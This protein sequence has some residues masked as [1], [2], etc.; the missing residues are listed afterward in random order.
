MHVLFF[1]INNEKFI[2][3]LSFISIVKTLDVF[4]YLQKKKSI[5]DASSHSL[6][7]TKPVDSLEKK[8]GIYNWKWKKNYGEFCVSPVSESI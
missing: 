3:L 8:M 5:L 4:H 2:G 1:R 7:R 6:P